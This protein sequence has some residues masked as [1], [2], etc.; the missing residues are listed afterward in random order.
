MPTFL[1]SSSAC[2]SKINSIQAAFLLLILLLETGARAA[3]DHKAP[4]LMTPASVLSSLSKQYKKR[5][6]MLRRNESPDGMRFTFLS[7]APLDDYKSFAEGERVCVMIPEAHFIWTRSD[8][9]GHGFADLRIE[10]RDQDTMFSF[11]LV[12][13]ATVNVNQTFNRL[14]ISFITNEYATS[15]GTR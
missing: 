1:P 14:D 6:L 15:K 2:T 13:G 3:T 9:S 4:S 11:R 7:D 8:T 12:Q 5:I 10:Q